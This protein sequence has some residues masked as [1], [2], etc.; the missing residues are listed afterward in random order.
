[1]AALAFSLK[2]AKRAQTKMP[3]SLTQKNESR[4]GNTIYSI[5]YNVQKLNYNLS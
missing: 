1:V 4:Q 3:Q 2:K 5:I